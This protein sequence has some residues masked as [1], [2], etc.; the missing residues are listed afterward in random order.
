MEHIYTIPIKYIIEVEVT[1]K[2]TESVQKVYEDVKEIT[3]TV[4]DATSLSNC[5]VV[6]KKRFIARSKILKS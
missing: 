1:V 2:S 4:T 6:R 3:A 5:V